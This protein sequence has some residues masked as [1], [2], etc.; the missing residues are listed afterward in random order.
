VGSEVAHAAKTKAQWDIVSFTSFSPPTFQAGGKASALAQDGSKITV[1]GS[2][3]FR[4]AG[5]SQN[6]TGGGTWETRD[7][8][9]N[10]NGSGTYVVTGKVRFDE[11]PGTLS[12]AAVD[13]IADKATAHSGLLALTVMYSDESEGILVVSCHLPAGTPDT[14]FEG[15]TATKG[16]VDYWNAQAPAAGVDGNRTVFHHG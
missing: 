14:I 3:T 12:A 13:N 1:T 11:A 16:F 9:G 10:L 7:K 2:G 5:K 4:T 6:V 15:I 8:D